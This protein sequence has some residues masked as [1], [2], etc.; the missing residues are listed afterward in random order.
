MWGFLMRE[1][2]KVMDHSTWSDEEVAT[3][4][5][6]YRDGRHALEADLA[7][8][9][10]ERNVPEEVASSPEVV[11]KYLSKLQHRVGDGKK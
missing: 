7:A 4:G 6:G 5:R 1:G 3:Y 8:A 9:L 11:A 2:F 10:R